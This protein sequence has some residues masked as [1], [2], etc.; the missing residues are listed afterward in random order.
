MKNALIIG[1]GSDIG[2]AITRKL[3]S[4]GYNTTS[5]YNNSKIEAEKLPGKIIHCDITD[6]KQIDDVIKEVWVW[7]DLLV[8]SAFPFIEWDNFDFETYL[9]VQKIL[10]WHI[11]TITETSKIMNDGWKIVNILGQCVERWLPGWAAYSAAFAFLHNY[12]NSI[13]AK[14]WKTW[15]ISALDMLLWPVDT[16]EWDWLS[17]EVIQ[18]YK[19]KVADFITPEQV[20]DT[21]HF[22]INQKVMPST[23]KLDGYYGY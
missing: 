8:T 6:L 9:E 3:N 2:W 14:E 4:E 21:I 13:N 19:S 18:R 16:R 17:E 10:T 7:V 11:Y 1:W 22:L 5:T 23:F 20:A 15:K 12:S